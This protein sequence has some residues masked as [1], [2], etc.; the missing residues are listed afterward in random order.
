MQRMNTNHE[1][2]SLR[3]QGFGVQ[4]ILYPIRLFAISLTLLNFVIVS[5]L[6]PGTRLKSK[7]LIYYAT[8]HN[9]LLLLRM[10]KVSKIK[11]S[12]AD[13]TMIKSGKEAKDL[14]FAF[15]NPSTKQLNLIFADRL[16]VENEGMLIGENVAFISNLSSK[17]PNGFDHLIL[18]NYRSIQN[19]SFAIASLLHETDIKR[20]SLQQ[21]RIKPLM[22]KTLF[23]SSHGQV[24][25]CL[26]EVARRC[27]LAVITF[28]FTMM[29]ALFSIQIG[30]IKRKTGLLTIFLLTLVSLTCYL[31]AKKPSQSMSFTLTLFALPLIAI[32]LANMWKKHRIERG[33]E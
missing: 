27:F 4:E 22:I 9:P 15:L 32:L 24:S 1:L 5:E 8:A 17:K 26:I 23:D 11:N 10:N 31:L 18:E 33:I 2:T 25:D 14:T 12:Y 3:S 21:L 28:S 6:T 19:S 30:R 29:G 20:Q 16:L 13:L 7:N